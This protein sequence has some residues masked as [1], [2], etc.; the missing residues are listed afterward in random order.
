MDRRK[1]SD[2]PH[3]LRTRLPRGALAGKPCL[4]A[5]ATALHEDGD[6]AAVSKR[7]GRSLRSV[8]SKGYCVEL[9]EWKSDINDVAVPIV[10]DEARES[11]LTLAC[12][13][14]PQMV[15]SKKLEKLGGEMVIVGKEIEHLFV[16][17]R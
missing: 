7:I 13:G 4:A 10:L 16:R 15:P 3:G 1:R 5:R 8:A 6:W 9:G 12:G 14:P 17:R 11:V 2:R